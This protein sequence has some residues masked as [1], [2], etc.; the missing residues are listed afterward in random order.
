MPRKRT[1][2]RTLGG[3]KEKWR[4]YVFLAHLRFVEGK[5][6]VTRIEP[7]ENETRKDNT[8]LCFSIPSEVL[9]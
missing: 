4:V 5:R 6:G 8:I 3:T 9:I 2:I 1:R 7:I